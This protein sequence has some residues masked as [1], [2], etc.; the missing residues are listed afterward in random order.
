MT[1]GTA[2]ALAGGAGPGRALD[3]LE[4]GLELVS[5]RIAFIGVLG[6]LAVAVV[7]VVDVL[8]RWLFSSGVLALNE[9]VSLSVA[10]AVSATIPSGLARG[11]NLTVN[12]MKPRLAPWLAAGL[13]ALG[14]FLLLVFYAFLAWRIGIYASDLAHQGRTTTILSVP[15]GP[16]MYS[17]AALL[18]FGAFIQLV[19]TINTIRRVPAATAAVDPRSRP[20]AVV[21]AVA[22]VVLC[23]LA[24][25]VA[26]AIFAFPALA[27]WAQD[28]A[29]LT[30]IA[31]FLLMWLSLALLVPLAA[32]MGLMGFLGIALF[33][34]TGPASSAF[35]TEAAGF[36]Y[37]SQVA[38]LP[39]FLLMGSF[40]AVAGM[41]DDVYRL[42]QAVLGAFR[43]GLAMATI[44]GCAGFGA[45]TGSSLATV[46]TFGRVALPG[47]REHGYAMP[48]ATGCIAAGGTLGALIPPSGMLILYAL[49]T[50]EL[51]G[52]LFV[53]AIVP[54][55]LAAALY[56]V[57]IAVYVRVAPRS[58]PPAQRWQ[59]AE[60]TGAVRQSGA[61][62]GLFATVIGGMYAGIFTSVEAASVGTFGAFM[63]A[64]LRGRLKP[65]AFWQLMGE[66]TATTGLIYGLIFGAV[67]FSFFV[68]ASGLPDNATAYLA[69][70]NAPP[71]A[72]IGLMLVVYLLLGCVM[73]SVAIMVITVPIVAPL[74]Q[75]LGYDLIWWGVVMVCVVETGMITPPFG[76][77]IF[78]LTSMVEDVSLSE[79][80][81][82]VSAF[83]AADVV[84]LALLVLIPALV[85]WLPST[86]FG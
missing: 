24:A 39:L 64:L 18:A 29:T 56:L 38:T 28:N 51:I 8:L 20:S 35:A 22:V 30:V 26:I 40:A 73:D 79:I 59:A 1:D 7:T 50:E 19:V 84:K 60:L 75:T 44:G 3:R 69:D 82:G 13:G 68:A 31:A 71:I 66:T 80:F 83:V 12:I 2:G 49:L 76:V 86:M 41:S 23:A 67:T 4:D 57:A 52:Q 5:R 9:L 55:L 72:V 85:L 37:N 27:D 53:A 58:V 34:G 33:L 11:V 17:A 42:A 45:V 74:I 32:V 43:G 63:V 25:L 21:T 10:V 14:A 65:G 47:M 78:L 62:M 70:L 81:K 16:F 77:N 6:I 54:G 61:A 48:L 46:A 36:L 15:E